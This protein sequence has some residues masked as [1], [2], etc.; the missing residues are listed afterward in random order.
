MKI[1][2]LTKYYS[3]GASS[4]YRYYNYETYFKKNKI[5]VTYKPLMYDGYVKN[6]YMN[7]KKSKIKLLKD[8]FYRIFYIILN[9]RKFDHIIIEKE[10]VMYCPYFIEK[11]LL[12]KT[13][14]SLD[15]DDNPNAPYFKN[16]FINKL[17]RNKINN[18]VK[19]S[20]ICTVGN[21]WYFQEFK[22]QNLRY[23]PT[24]VDITK[25]EKKTHYMIDECINIVWIGSKSTVKYLKIVE[26]IL[27]ELSQKYNIKLKLIGA[28]IFLEKIKVE[29]I[30]W[31][32]EIEA[33][34]ILKSDIGIMPLKEDYWEKGKCGFKL[35]Q[36]MASGLPVVASPSPANEEIVEQYVNGY[37]AK[38]N[39]EWKI[40]L[41]KLIININARKDMGNINRDKIEKKYSYQVWG[42]KYVNYIK[43]EN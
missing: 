17:Y 34:E 23:L 39:E 12:K 21:K 38:T 33:I 7:K 19:N 37:I 9:K 5:E 22:Y 14:Y 8:V 13:R 3:E 4:R 29:Y 30:N 41:E 16:K 20:Y 42:N 40:A 1:L 2:F 24:V 15:F 27:Q 11:F 28:N 6:Y 18:L 43:G 36:Y 35:I 10:L 32:E 26:P 31:N 25:Y